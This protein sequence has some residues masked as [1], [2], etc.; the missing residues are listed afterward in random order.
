MNKFTYNTVIFINVTKH[1]SKI[2]NKKNMH[3]I[4]KYLFTLHFKSFSSDSHDFTVE[5]SLA[6]P[7]S[8]WSHSNC[9][10]HFCHKIFFNF[11]ISFTFLNYGICKKWQ[12]CP[13]QSS[14]IIIC[15]GFI[16]DHNKVRFVLVVNIK[17]KKKIAIGNRFL[18]PELKCF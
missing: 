3:L 4:V 8:N 11:G 14:R 2:I 12:K 7:L 10:N 1:N 6:G 13:L 9:L 15:L 17:S 5:Q 16:P 18:Y